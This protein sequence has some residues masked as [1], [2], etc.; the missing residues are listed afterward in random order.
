MN[1]KGVYEAQL[2][3]KDTGEVLQ[4]ERFENLITDTGYSI[5][6]FGTRPSYLFIYSGSGEGGQDYRRVSSPTSV[7]GFTRQESNSASESSLNNNNSFRLTYSFAAPVTTIDISAFGSGSSSILYSF[8]SLTNPIVQTPGTILYLSYTIHALV[9]NNSASMGAV[10]NA[11]VNASILNCYITD[12][13]MKP[14]SLL[15]LIF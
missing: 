5:L 9:S 8:V 12:L 3:H 15:P 4:E 11:W 6:L 7:P 13:W 10:S 1:F 2:I 14:I